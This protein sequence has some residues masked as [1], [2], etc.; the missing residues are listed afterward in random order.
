MAPK[1]VLWS[2]PIL[3]MGPAGALTSGLG[4][5]LNTDKDVQPI[6]LRVIA[7]SEEMKS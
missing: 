4:M 1:V 5:E 2:V 6:R 3:P 7:E